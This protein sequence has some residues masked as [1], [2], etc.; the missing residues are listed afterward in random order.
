[1]EELSKIIESFD[2]IKFTYTDT[3]E[4]LNNIKEKISYIGNVYINLVKTHVIKEYNFGLDS[5]H[6]QNK[7]IEI[8]YNN[9]CNLLN[10]IV[11]R[12]YCEY[13]KLY[14]FIEQYM[15]NELKLDDKIIVNKKIPVYKDLDKNINYDFLLTIELQ[16]TIVKYINEL[17]CHL[18]VKNSELNADT[19]QSKIGIHIENILNY[20]HYSNTLLQEKIMMYIRYLDALNKQHTKYINRLFENSK[21]L[22]NSINEDIIINKVKEEP[23]KLEII[24]NLEEPI[25]IVEKDT[26]SIEY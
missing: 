5:F 10:T 21:L 19:V 12:F 1:M 23:I 17:N 14:K 3:C 24:S 15:I 2:K 18:S 26:S 8:E 9:N 6:F 20:Q 4:L 13:Y 22:I 16:L 7:L 25:V 11:N